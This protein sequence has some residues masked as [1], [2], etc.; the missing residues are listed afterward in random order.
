[1]IWLLG[2]TACAS[3]PGPAALTEVR[4]PAAPAAPVA[5]ASG[6]ADQTCPPVCIPNTEVPDTE[7][8]RAILSFCESYRRAMEQADAPALLRLASPK[9]LSDGGTNDPADDVDYAALG[10]FLR[11]K[12][13]Q[14]TGMRLEI[15]YRRIRLEH[16]RIMVEHT[17]AFSFRVADGTWKRG[18]NDNTLVLEKTADGFEILSGM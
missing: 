9:Y 6:T 14:T 17:S 11:D 2:V 1:M 16:S 10:D 8:N 3:A 15:R 7:E 5:T 13:L 18:V 12:F 4:L